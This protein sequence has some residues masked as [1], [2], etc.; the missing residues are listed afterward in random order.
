MSSKVVDLYYKNKAKST[1]QFL[2][3][4]IKQEVKNPT[5]D[6]IANK[7]SRYLVNAIV[8]ASKDISMN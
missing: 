4:Q 1:L 8:F 5:T 7:D 3:S 6:V 2:I